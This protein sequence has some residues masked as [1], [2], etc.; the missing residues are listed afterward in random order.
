MEPEINSYHTSKQSVLKKPF[1]ILIVIIIGLGLVWFFLS[2][3]GFLNNSQ[4]LSEEDFQVE[5]ERLVAEA[6]TQPFVFELVP[7]A[8]EVITLPPPSES[9]VEDTTFYQALKTPAEGKTEVDVANDTIYNFPFR[10]TNYG[11]FINNS[12]YQFT[13]YQLHDEIR[14]LVAY[15]NSQYQRQPLSQRVE[16]VTQIGELE[17]AISEQSD[18][19]AV[20]PNVRSTEA[21]LV[22]NILSK[23]DPENA[24]KYMQ[25]AEEMAERGIAYG[26][27]GRSDMEASRSLVSQYL[28][29][30][31]QNN[32]DLI[33][34]VTSQNETN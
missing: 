31:Y 25:I 5:V 14:Q 19:A 4:P 6:E 17:E 20:Y 10:D 16:G 28:S 3:Q 21:F 26:H 1:G 23:L 9:T 18:T 34:I 22:A 12:E 15:F 24:T 8:L 27:Y 32:S 2:S 11:D 13:L 7:N 30:F 29:L 33:D